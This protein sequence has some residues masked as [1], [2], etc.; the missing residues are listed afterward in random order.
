ML[1]ALHG[2]SVATSGDQVRVFEHE[3]RAFSHTLDGR[4]GRPVNNGVA[5]VTVL[6]ASAMQADALASALTVMGPAAGVAYAEREDLAVRLI[7]RGPDGLEE[8]FSPAFAAMLD[9]AS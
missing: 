2:L 9:D 5:S 8:R 1:A 4:T 3:G 7:L 6:H